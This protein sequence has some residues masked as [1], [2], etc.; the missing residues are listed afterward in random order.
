MRKGLP[1]EELLFMSLE[2][3]IR[4]TLLGVVKPSFGLDQSERRG[5]ASQT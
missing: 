5:V 4:I 2:E 1:T 3:A